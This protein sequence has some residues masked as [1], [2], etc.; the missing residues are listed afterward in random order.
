VG[1]SLGVSLKHAT[2]LLK[3][4]VGM[5]EKCPGFLHAFKTMH[6]YTIISLVRGVS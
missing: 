1:K 4:I 6:Y 3:F 5:K 2:N